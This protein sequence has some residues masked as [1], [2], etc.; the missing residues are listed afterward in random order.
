[1]A[2][3]IIGA[4]AVLIL[5]VL[6]RFDLLASPPFDTG[7]PPRKAINLAPLPPRFVV[8]DLETT[9]LDPVRNEII[10]IG[11]IRVNRDSGIHDTFRTLVKPVRHIPKNITQINGISQ[12]MVDSEGMPLE[13][14]IKE[15]AAFIGDLPLVTFN[16][17]FDMAFLRKAAN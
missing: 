11:A 5:L 3:L 10:E 17:D 6:Q 4:I 12:E 7:Q 15:F 14:A 13:Q 2:W 16:A 8:L 1:M 9:G